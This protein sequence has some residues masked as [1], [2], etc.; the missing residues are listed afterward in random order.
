M[1]Q[2]RNYRPRTEYDGKVLFSQASDPWDRTADGMHSPPSHRW[3]TP[4]HDRV[5]PARDQGWGIPWPEMG[6][7]LARD[8]VPTR[9]RTADWVLDTRRAVCLL[10]S[11]RR[12]VLLF[13]L[14]W[15]MCFDAFMSKIVSGAQLDGFC[16]SLDH[17]EISRYHC[18]PMR[19]SCSQYCL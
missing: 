8:G 17:A 12:I 1:R 15:E 13:L 11:R 16:F 14:L 9:D 19:Q 3:L 4:G 5:P 2:Y 18:C 10:R 6:Y 7:T